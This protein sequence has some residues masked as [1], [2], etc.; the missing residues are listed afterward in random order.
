LY[1]RAAPRTNG[2][3][4]MVVGSLTVRRWQR[5]AAWGRQLRG[6]GLGVLAGSAMSARPGDL[7]S[8]R[9]L[10]IGMASTYGLIMTPGSGW[11]CSGR[12]W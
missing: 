2:E 3:A 8:Q 7:G 10:A 12:P 4:G 6:A 11:R 9:V 1:A 5:H